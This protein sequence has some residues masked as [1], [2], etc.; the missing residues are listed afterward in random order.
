MNTRVLTFIAYQAL[1]FAVV[2]AA[3]H[4]RGWLACAACLAFVLWQ[5]IASAERAVVWR[6]AFLAVLLGMLV[7]GGATVAG[8]VRYAAK[9][10]MPFPGGPPCWILGLWASFAVTLPGPMRWLSGRPV[11]AALLG[12]IGGPLSYAGAQ[13][14]WSA[15]TFPAPVWQGYAWLAVSWAVAMAVLAVA[16]AHLTSGRAATVKR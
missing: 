10:P 2:V 3:G 16:L 1:W 11:A 13:R 9:D 14:G 6:L 5:S 7:D 15:V 8:V 12:A 4:D